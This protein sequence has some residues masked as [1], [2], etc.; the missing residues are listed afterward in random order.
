MN[1]GSFKNIIDK[2]CLDII[3]LIGM[4]KKDLGLDNLQWLICHEIKPSGRN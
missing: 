2:I 3:D 4:Y 1:S